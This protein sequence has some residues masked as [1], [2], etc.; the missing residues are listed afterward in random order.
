MMAKFFITMNRQITIQAQF[1][2]EAESEDEAKNKALELAS[3]DNP[4]DNGIDWDTDR[5]MWVDATDPE[6]TGTVSLD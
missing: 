1:D 2:I 5:T 6:V 4:R 3:W